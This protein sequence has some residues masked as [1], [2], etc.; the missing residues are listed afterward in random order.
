MFVYSI[1]INEKLSKH[2]DINAINLLLN[3]TWEMVIN[4]PENHCGGAVSYEYKRKVSVL[5]RV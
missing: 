2:L 4:H 3:I 5:V 1:N